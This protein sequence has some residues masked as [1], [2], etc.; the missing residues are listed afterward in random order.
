MT[1]AK[2]TV[3]V[4]DNDDPN[5]DSNNSPG[6]GTTGDN[7]V[8]DINVSDNIGVQAVFIMWGHGI[9]DGNLS[10]DD[11]GD[12]TWSGTIVLDDDLRNLT[13]R[14][15]FNDT[16][17]NFFVTT[18]VNVTVTDNDKPNLDS[19][20]SPNAGT[21]GDIFTFDITVSD[22][23]EV[24][25]INVTWSHGDLSGND[26]LNDDVDDTW[27]LSIILDDSL[28]DLKY[29]IQVNDTSG[30]FIRNG[31][32]TITVTDDD[33]PSLDNDNSPNAGTTGDTYTFDITVSDNID[34]ASVNVTWAHGGLWDNV[35]LVDDGDDTWSL[36]ITL[37]HSLGGLTY[38]IQVNDTSGNF[39][40]NATE[41]ITVSDN[42][43][44]NLDADITPNTGT[45]GD[46]LTINITALDNIGVESVN[47]TW[48][49]GKFRYDEPLIKNG[50]GSWALTVTLDHNITDLTYSVQIN[51]TTGNYYRCVKRS[52]AVSDND[53]PYIESDD[54]PTGGTTGDSY[55]F[56]FTISDNIDV[57]SVNVTW[58]HGANHGNDTLK[59]NGDGF[60]SF[61]VVLDHSLDILAYSIQVND[62]SGN[63]YRTDMKDV[64]ITDN[65]LP[66]FGLNETPST[67]TTGDAVAFMINVGE[68]IGISEVFVEYWYGKVIPMTPDKIIMSGTGQLSAQLTALDTLDDLNYR[69][70]ARDTSGNIRVSL[71]GAIKMIDDDSPM[72]LNYRTE[73]EASITDSIVFSVDIGENIGL[74]N[75]TVEYWYG[76]DTV[77]MTAELNP[78]REGSKTY[79]TKGIPIDKDTSSNLYYIFHVIDT[80]GNEFSSEM[81]MINITELHIDTDGDGKIDYRDLDDDGD[82]MSDEWETAHGLDPLNADDAENDDDGDGLTNLRE[83]ELGTRPDTN[84][85]DNDG[86]A[87]GWEVNNSLDPRTNDA[88]SDRDGDNLP[89]M[90]EYRL[91]TDP[92]NED[93]DGDGISDGDEVAEGSDPRDSRSMPEKE[94]DDVLFYIF[95]FGIEYMDILG[96]V[97][98]VL[99]FLLGFLLLTRKRRLYR[100][101][102]TRLSEIEDPEELK[103]LYKSEVMPLIEKEKFTPHHSV[104]IKD[105]YDGKRS[106]LKIGKKTDHNLRTYKG[107]FRKAISD[108]EITADEESMLAELRETLGIDMDVH[109]GL[110]EEFE[111]KLEEE[112]VGEEMGPGDEDENGG[113]GE[114]DLREEDEVEDGV[115]EE[116]EEEEDELGSDEGEAE[117]GEEEF[118]DIEEGEAELGKEEFEDR[119]EGEEGTEED[120]SWAN[121]GEKEE[122]GDGE[123]WD[124]E[125]TD[126]ELGD[127]ELWDNEGTDEELGDDELWDSEDT[128]EGS[129]DDAIVDEENEKIS[130]VTDDGEENEDLP[131]PPS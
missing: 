6:S 57:S 36:T 5:L 92:G 99:S 25:T 43:D 109:N 53:I 12:G 37:D 39:V 14:I 30:N 100:R 101:Y 61:T 31:I 102:R 35:A 49:H 64:T 128:D 106:E 56:D 113:P 77:H 87:D 42:D 13:Y 52:V 68:N 112:E 40:R 32:E 91:G 127:D 10:L 3:T 80:S 119:E 85:T 48:S 69:F 125:G 117:L 114:E 34:V 19:D 107:A 33:N 58:R 78:E 111:G 47:V 46:K 72:I 103:E 1:I 11:D 105:I 76:N 88:G 9:R 73:G 116:E 95:G 44:P 129:D 7:Y 90:D 27:S 79:L 118:E 22:N 59:D 126:E 24:G 45:T 17:D 124:S 123:L 104:L 60:W 131:S 67:A 28:Q 66:V 83:W 122:L 115:E 71:I 110:M 130:D 98:S 97:A 8:F 38:N 121:E 81:R 86:M 74:K 50:D 75:A 62:S 21:T 15:W 120:E 94:E 65:D 70:T 54:S 63:Y 23:I 41:T 18:V 26:P 93:T 55:T 82:E 16:S 89:N 84:D 51:D 4:T 108:G 2:R 20:A 29:E 96:A